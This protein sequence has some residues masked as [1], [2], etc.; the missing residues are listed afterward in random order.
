LESAPKECAR[1]DEA[2]SERQVGPRTGEETLTSQ[3]NPTGERPRMLS[4]DVLKGNV[5]RA[6]LE[7]FDQGNL[8][9][10]DELFAPDVV[11]HSTARPKLRHGAGRSTR[12]SS[13]AF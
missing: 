13:L 7:V 10:I 2:P 6:F 4:G 11:F 8:S 3:T 12:S 9:A 1:L 5:R